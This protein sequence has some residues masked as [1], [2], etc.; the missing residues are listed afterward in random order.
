M[1]LYDCD[2]SYIMYTTVSDPN[3]WMLEVH[4]EQ[5]FSFR[6]K[7]I[8][9]INYSGIIAELSPRSSTLCTVSFADRYKSIDACSGCVEYGG[10]AYYG[11]IQWIDARFTDLVEGRLFSNLSHDDVITAV[12]SIRVAATEVLL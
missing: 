11:S 7:N 12:S 10:K 9:Y 4:I 8:Y 6:S 2:F 1:M 3:D 5:D